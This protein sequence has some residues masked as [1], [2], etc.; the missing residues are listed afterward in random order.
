MG[1]VYKAEDTELGRFVA[2]KFLPEELAQD[3]QALER[4]RREA[5]AASALNH[6]NICTIYEIGEHEGRRFIAM[7][8]LDGI[9]LKH[10][11][12]GRPLET[13]ALLSAAIEIAD[14]L[15][16]AHAEG[17]VHRDIKPA[18]IFMTK[19]GHAKILDFGLA[20]VTPTTSSSSQM[21]AAN[22]QTGTIDEQ[23]LTSPGSTL[24]TVAYMSPE[25][26]RAK[27]LDARTDLFSF[28]AVLYEMA[29]G[30]L[31]FR[32]ESTGVIFESIL[33]RTPAPAVRLSPDVPP[34]LEEII[35]KCLEKDRN[36]RYQ[37]ASEIRT[38]LQRLKRD[39]ETGRGV[40]E[41]FAT[42][43][44]A[45]DI[46]TQAGALRSGSALASSP[47]SATG[48]AVG[49]V[50]A[51]R[52][53]WKVGSPIAVLVVVALIAAGFY[54]RSHSERQLT[55]K[56][57]V[58]LADFV[59]K[60]GDPVFDDTLKQGLSVELGQSP[61]LNI[62]S[63]QEVRQTLR[64]MGRSPNDPVTPEVA[65]QVCVRSGSKALLVGS[66][67]AMG[68]EYVLGLEAIDCNSGHTLAKEQVEAATKEGVLKALDK[69]AGSLRVKLG[70]SLATVEKYG[71]TVEQ[72]T[73]P[74]LEAL[75]AY[76][77]G[78]RMFRTKGDEAAIPLYMQAV[79][80]DP[81]FAMA[82]A[83]LGLI[84]SR[85]GETV[86]AIKNTKRAY[87]LRE[88]VSEQERLYI[89][90]HY[91]GIV[92][93]DLDR[94]AQTYQLWQEEYPRDT[95][96]YTN[97]GGIYLWLGQL[98]KALPESQEALRLNP[99]SVTQY[100]NLAKAYTALNRF[101]EAGQ[102]LEQARSRHLESAALLDFSYDLAFLQ[103]E[104]AATQRWV[105]A[106]QGKRGIEDDLLDRASA[107]E[108]FYG[109]LGKSQELSKEAERVALRN[110]NK[111]T[112][113]G[114]QV[115]MALRETEQG[116]NAAAEHDAVAALVIASGREVKTVAALVLA[117]AGY[118]ARAEALLDSLQKEFPSNTIVNNYWLPTIRAAIELNRSNASHALELLK[119]AAPSELAAG[120]GGNL[121]PVYVRGQALLRLHQGV[122]AASEFQK[123]LDHRGIVLNEPIG[124]LAHLGLGRAYALQGD[125]AR[126]KSAYQDFLT[127]WKNADLEIPILKEAKAEYAKLQ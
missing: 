97:L 28:G 93:G 127:L 16:A 91:Y 90:S 95:V 87:E 27:E 104:L 36:L 7:E 34:K 1:V 85:L 101:V 20:K 78:L 75:R 59:N 44:V 10:M 63:E 125:T 123:I 52:K 100:A 26:V 15:D 23:H 103:G 54:Y 99:D 102:I 49:P 18:N 51:G 25:Q 74:S 57:T 61:F 39:T 92:T 32:G 12:T 65:K 9:T 73:T 82:Y 69:A 24:G 56:G 62:V 79:G 83:R 41:N 58:V 88:G 55:E 89:E 21:A 126:A 5:R 110:D 30:A 71:T 43:V 45:Q 46:D 76:S 115:A 86:L 72:A 118:A 60:T 8:Y 98:D 14:G 29:T 66:V 94:A 109:R 2:L 120:I 22:T 38:D 40:A 113:S 122:A 13:E 11:I 6:P 37:H 48:A 81:K 53:V 35:N 47:K 70:E 112:A 67:S 50:S 111:E 3:P 96:P 31:P 33:N 106:A 124:A 119:V 117:Q 107:T 84:Y 114:Y 64:L 105:A 68:S 4:F 42:A 80:L 19:R 17:I 108:A 77:V 121:Y 116:N